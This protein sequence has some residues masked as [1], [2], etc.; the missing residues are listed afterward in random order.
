[1]TCI[2]TRKF[3]VYTERSFFIV[4]IIFLLYICLPFLF[5]LYF[6]TKT[7]SS[8]TFH[9]F[10][11]FI[12]FVFIY[13]ISIAWEKNDYENRSTS[14]KE[15]YIRQTYWET[16]YKHMYYIYIYT[17]GLLIFATIILLQCLKYRE[18]QFYLYRAIELKK[19][20]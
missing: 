19:K 12:L 7:M 2:G 20:K 15:Y 8:W 6:L 5:N 1:M 10:L 17:A 14:T 16:R 11:K 13:L 3:T 9:P 18:L 4:I